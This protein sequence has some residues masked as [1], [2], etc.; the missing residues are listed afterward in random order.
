MKKNLFLFLTLLSLNGFAQKTYYWVGTASG[1]WSSANSWNTVRGSSSGI[2]RVS[3]N[4]GDTLVF[5]G[6]SIAPGSFASSGVG[7]TLTD[8]STET[9]AYLI[10]IANEAGSS[11][12]RT[13]AVTLPIGT[14]TL[15]IT[16]DLLISYS[17]V[18]NDGG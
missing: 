8:L 7:V 12:G 6:R 18:L 10:I 17:S 5:D 14:Q 11:A 13:I 16:N 9:I 15:T 1:A 2:S 3:P 4:A